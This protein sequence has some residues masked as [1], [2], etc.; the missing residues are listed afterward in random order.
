[1]TV[2]IMLAGVLAWNITSTAVIADTSAVSPQAP[3]TTKLPVDRDRAPSMMQE[4]DIGSLSAEELH[5]K[6]VYDSKNE[7]VATVKAVSGAPG[8][9]REATLQTGGVLGVGSTDVTLPLDK[10]RVGP[11]GRLMLT[12][13]ESELK[14]LPRAE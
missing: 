4:I 5:D 12:M 6:P 8:S 1:M 7:Q 10:L 13:T 2:R 11:D 3:G 9:P 14:L